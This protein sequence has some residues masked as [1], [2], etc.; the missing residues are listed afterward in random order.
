MNIDNKKFNEIKKEAESWYKKVDRVECP[1]LKRKVIFNSKGLDHIKFKAWNK[2]RLISDQYMRF[3]FLRLAPAV[4]EKSG[5]LQEYEETKCFERWKS[6][7]KWQKILVP[8]VYY[9]FVA[10]LNN[11]IRVKVIVKE[12]DGGNPFFWSIIPFW[13][14]RKHPITGEIKKVF[15]E[16]DLEN[17]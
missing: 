5:T 15:H 17:D 7:S 3:K 16:G 11:K 10:I 2:S 14:N 9:G 1:Y 6:S 12:I 8:V 4:L 13:R